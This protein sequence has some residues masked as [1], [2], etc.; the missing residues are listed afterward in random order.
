MMR[1]V[2][3]MWSADHGSLRGKEEEEKSATRMDMV[4]NGMRDLT[5]SVA[6]RNG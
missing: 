5:L 3:K 4:T 2:G 1:I 6:Q